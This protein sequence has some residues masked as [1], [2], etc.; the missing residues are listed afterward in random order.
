MTRRKSQ[1]VAEELMRT[2]DPAVLRQFRKGAGFLDERGPAFDRRLT[3]AQAREIREAD[4]QLRKE[5][6]ASS[7]RVLLWRQYAPWL[8]AFG[9]LV[10]GGVEW[11]LRW[12]D[13]AM[14][15]FTFASLAGLALAWAAWMVGRRT[16]RW[17]GRVHFAAGVASVWLLWTAASGPSWWAVPVL[18]LG[19]W[20]SSAA[21]W[22]VNRP[23]H[24]TDPSPVPVPVLNEPTIPELWDAN[25]GCQ[26]GR[27]AGA[28]LS[29]YAEDAKDGCEAYCINLRPGKQTITETLSLL[30]IIAGGLM[31]PVERTMLEPDPDRNPNHVKLTIVQHSPIEET[32]AYCGARLTGSWRH[33]I[34]VGP[35][36]DG[37]GYARWRMWQPGE[38]PMTGSWLSGLVIAGTGIGKSRL[39]ELL[40]AGYMASGNAIV[41]FVDPQLGASS[42]ALQEYADWY[43]SGEGTG[44]MLTALELIAA[45]REKENSARGWTR[46]DPS[47]ERPGIVV[48][49]DEFHMSVARYAARLEALARKTQKV[50]ISIVGLTQG[51]SLE[52]LGKDTLRAS[53]M[54]NLIVMKTGSNQ[55]KNLLPGLPVD[56]ETLPK[57]AGFGY[58]SGDESRVATFRAEY[59]EDPAR[60]F[61]QYPMP[62]LDQMSANAAKDLYGMRHAEAAAEQEA[63]RLWVEQMSNGEMQPTLD[64]PDLDD[65]GTDSPEPAAFKVVQFPASPAARPQDRP[66]DKP[67]SQRIVALVAQ[68]V[69][70][71]A[72]IQKAIGLGKSQTQALL[73]KLVADQHLERPTVGVYALAGSVSTPER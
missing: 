28:K 5:R 16:K 31:T 48:F 47:P 25:L 71:T 36:G 42:P 18:A 8:A 52:S 33:M 37:D 58:M 6:R 46:F 53:M 39:M 64:E 11:L 22:K 61:K 57:I 14:V 59:V 66:Q 70:R 7:M 1:F 3:P 63:N 49:M 30:E 43:V 41:W 17:R 67:S 23:P 50:G 38:K 54:A 26:G 27:L 20:A 2:I 24:P 40:A 13:G 60:W 19:T 12:L 56:P 4:K 62:K 9:V 73:N 45:A 44:K 55:T 34:E 65:W 72:E 69:T 29:S 68:G 51:A 15:A 32:V 10:L 35:Y 21:W